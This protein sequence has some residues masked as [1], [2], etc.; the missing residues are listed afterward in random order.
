MSNLDD[1]GLSVEDIQYIMDFA[2]PYERLS[3]F[4][5]YTELI[6]ASTLSGIEVN[7][8]MTRKIIELYYWMNIPECE[9][10][11]ALSMLLLKHVFMAPICDGGYKC[12][13]LSIFAKE[14]S[15]ES[16]NTRGWR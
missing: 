11:F 10:S 1:R 3:S 12:P 9:L 16:S 7:A 2:P 13:K 4:A 6:D 14:E 5:K 8:E 15:L